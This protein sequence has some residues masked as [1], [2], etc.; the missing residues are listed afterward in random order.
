MPSP[1][2]SPAGAN[3]IR[4]AEPLHSV[5][6]ES[7]GN[8]SMVVSTKTASPACSRDLMKSRPSDYESKSLRPAGAAQTPP[9]CS[10]QRGRPAS[11]FQT[12]RVMAGG[13]TTGMTGLSHGS[14]TEPW[15]PSDRDRKLAAP[16]GSPKCRRCRLIV[17]QQLPTDN[18]QGKPPVREM[19]LRSLHVP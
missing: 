10:R 4:S 16:W 11:A 15:R 5:M 9:G 13:M 2:M 19:S 12:C 1:W 18:R 8:G 7:C 14:P 3:P 17:G 6:L